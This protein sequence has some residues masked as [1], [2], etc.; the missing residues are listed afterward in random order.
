MP[1]PDVVT[2][3]QLMREG[4]VKAWSLIPAALANVIK[5]KQWASCPDKN[6]VPF[7]SFEAFVQHR[8]WQ[9]LESSFDEL[10]IYCRK[11]PEVLKLIKDE[12]APATEHGGDHKSD[13]ARITLLKT[14]HNDTAHGVLRRLKRDHPELAEQVVAGELSANA[15]AI[16]A[17]FRK[18]PRK[19]CPNCGHEWR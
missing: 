8:L 15:A 6:G 9:G 16:E 10:T 17:G 14:P 18:K 13:Q 2:L 5:E 19:C 3:Q 12:M 11:K 1:P 7:V 4:G